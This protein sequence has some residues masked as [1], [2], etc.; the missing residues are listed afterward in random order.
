MTNIT[1]TDAFYS[2]IY[3]EAW[4]EGVKAANE[5][6]PVPMVVEQHANP[7]NDNSSVIA[8]YVVNDG[9]CGFAWVNIRPGN[10]GFARW[11]KKNNLAFKDY[12][13]GVSIYI[14]EYNQSMTKK[15]KHARAMAKYIRKFD[16]RAYAQSRMD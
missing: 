10:C 1:T 11:L 4:D 7:L 9:V 8:R 14:H 13:G 3:K 12:Y 2:S 16:I 15:E 5:C 6:I